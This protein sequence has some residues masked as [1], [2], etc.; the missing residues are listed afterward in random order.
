MGEEGED[1]CNSAAAVAAAAADC[2]GLKIQLICSYW[3]YDANYEMGIDDYD[4]CYKKEQDDD[5]DDYYDYGDYG[6]SGFSP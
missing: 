2:F 4:S 5:D 1:L 3:D 6:D